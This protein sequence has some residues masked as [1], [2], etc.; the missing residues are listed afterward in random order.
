VTLLDV[1][2][3][4]IR[5]SPGQARRL[6][7]ELLPA[8]FDRLDDVLLCATELVTNAVLHAATPCRLS[9]DRRGRRLVLRVCDSNPGAQPVVRQFDRT[10]VTGRGLQLVDRLTDRWGIDTDGETKCVWFEINGPLDTQV[11][12]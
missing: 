4:P 9:V 11:P 1:M 10:A 6:L 3:D 8:E 2:L 7:R 12:S 5:S